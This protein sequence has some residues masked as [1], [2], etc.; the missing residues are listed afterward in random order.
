M[1]VPMVAT[2]R[3]R[4]WNWNLGP[5]R[6]SRSVAFVALLLLVSLGMAGQSSRP[7]RM[8]RL[9][10]LTGEVRLQGG[11][12]SQAALNMPILE[13]TVLSTA[14]DG[15]AEVEFEDGSLVRLTPNSALSV[16]QLSVDEN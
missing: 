9:T 16:L 2:G 1:S 10:Y 11:A 15:K 12:E 14:V 8:A 5:N 3:R 4:N 7:T 13:G 6:C